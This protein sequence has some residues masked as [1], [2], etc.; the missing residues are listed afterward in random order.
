MRLEADRTADQ[1]DP[2]QSECGSRQLSSGDA[3][4]GGSVRSESENVCE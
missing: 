4:C 1:I 2:L 3:R